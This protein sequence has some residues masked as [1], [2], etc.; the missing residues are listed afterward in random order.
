MN[1]I[2]R[3]YIRLD[4]ISIFFHPHNGRKAKTEIQIPAGYWLVASS[5]WFQKI[6]IRAQKVVYQCRLLLILCFFFH[7][8]T[9]LSFNSLEVSSVSL[10]IKS[11]QYS[12]SS[13]T[14]LENLHIQAFEWSNHSYCRNSSGI[15]FW[16]KFGDST[17]IVI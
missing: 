9:I 17:V 13:G 5:F 2:N 14:C 10:E 7:S 15:V 11:Q 4:M 1:Q 16:A 12:D 8:R 6:C 3:N